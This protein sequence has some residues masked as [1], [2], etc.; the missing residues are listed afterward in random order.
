[1]AENLNQ[2]I[3]NIFIGD[4]SAS[5]SITL[6]EKKNI[7]SIVSVIK[8]SSSSF[9]QFDYLNIPI[10]DNLNTNIC[11]YFDIVTDWIQSKLIL[12]PHFGILIHCAAGVSRSTTLLAAFLM[13]SKNLSPKDAISLISSK[14][15]QVQPNDFFIYQLELYQ[16][17]N[18]QWDPVKVFIN[19]LNWISFLTCSLISH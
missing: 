1:M 12:Q 6:L 19:L 14:R 16:N 9:P 10:D 7:R 4:F 17:C 15:P 18:F 11:Q 8:H 3:P 2:I 13:K 5:Q